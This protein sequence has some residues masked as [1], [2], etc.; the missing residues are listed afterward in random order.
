[1]ARANQASDAAYSVW[2][3]YDRVPG[4]DKEQYLEQYSRLLRQ[5]PRITKRVVLG[6][7]YQGRKI[8]ALKVTRNARRRK[9]GKRPAVLYRRQ[10]AG[11]ALQ[12]AAERVT[13]Q[14][15]EGAVVATDD[16]VYTGLGL[17]GI[18]TEAKRHEFMNGVLR[19]LGILQ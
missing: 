9:D 7:T 4:D 5:Y 8:I 3:R 17:E 16:T 14:F 18:S 15:Q 12:R 19:H 13:E 2:T 6:R 1:M 10:A 11:G